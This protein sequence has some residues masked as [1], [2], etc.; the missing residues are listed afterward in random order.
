[1]DLSYF[2][3]KVVYLKA[4]LLLNTQL[5]I[6]LNIKYV[7]IHLKSKMINYNFQVLLLEQFN[8]INTFHNN[9]YYRKFNSRFLMDYFIFL[10]F[11]LI[12]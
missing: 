6:Y 12:N 7:V 5:T 3:L 9:Y 10:Y 4:F 2:K 11:L 8:N 1:M